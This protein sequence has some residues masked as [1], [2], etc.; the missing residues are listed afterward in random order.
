M[1]SLTKLKQQRILRK[2]AGAAAVEFALIAIVFFTLLL[3][4]IEFG[5]MFYV[6]NSVQEVTRRAAREAVVLWVDQTATAKNLALFGSSALPAGAEVGAANI[7]IDY[8]DN[9]GNP[10]ASGSLPSSPSDNIA[11]C[12]GNAANCIAAVR[13]QIN[14]AKYVPMMGLFPFLNISIPASTVTMP[15]ES[16][17]YRL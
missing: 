9:G 11:A 4:I 7:R 15:A 14:G 2:Q 8:L 5:R 3:G 10:I 16:M 13:V 1:L 12:L 17:G 6:W